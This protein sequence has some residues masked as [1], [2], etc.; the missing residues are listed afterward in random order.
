M[1]PSVLAPFC[2]FLGLSDSQGQ[3]RE[4]VIC[5]LIMDGM[6]LEESNI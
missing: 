2:V 5:L 4:E 1:K 6:I 3:Q